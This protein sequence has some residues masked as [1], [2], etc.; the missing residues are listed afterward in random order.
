MK[1]R[2]KKKADQSLFKMKHYDT[3][4]QKEKKASFCP[5]N[6][7]SGRPEKKK[8]WSLSL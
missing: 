1:N 2:K 4:L 5:N 3:L 7:Y 6:I 8:W